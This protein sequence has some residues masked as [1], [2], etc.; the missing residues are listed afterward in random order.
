MLY[1][2]KPVPLDYRDHVVVD[3]VHDEADVQKFIETLYNTTMAEDPSPVPLKTWCLPN[4]AK[5][6]LVIM[7]FLHD[8]V[9]G[10]GALSFIKQHMDEEP[11]PPAHWSRFFYEFAHVF[12]QIRYMNSLKDI[13]ETLTN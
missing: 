8:M 10:E 4:A 5:G 3:H 2:L 7:A 6:P 9:D 11:L 12:R 1:Y 13:Q